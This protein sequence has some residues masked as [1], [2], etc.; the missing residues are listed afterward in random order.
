MLSLYGNVKFPNGRK[1]GQVRLNRMW[2]VAGGPNNA[3]C[4]SE[5]NIWGT[6][7]F[8]GSCSIGTDCKICIGD[9]GILSVGNNCL[10]MTDCNITAYKEVALGDNLLMAHSSQ[11]LDT[12]Y[13]FVENLDNGTVKSNT[14]PIRIGNNCWICN[15]VSIMGGVSIP[16]SVIVASHSLVNKTLNGLLPDSLIG[17]IPA[18]ILS[19]R[20]RRIVDHK[21]EYSLGKYFMDNPEAAWFSK[22]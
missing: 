6:W 20:V 2:H 21:E 17:G 11:I 4:S 8:E 3:G 1:F 16:D 15:N 18:N 7:I 12:S 22:N 9:N 14:T 19:K 10:I 13:H 5:F